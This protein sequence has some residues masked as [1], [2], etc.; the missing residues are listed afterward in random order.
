MEKDTC[1]IQFDSELLELP[2]AL[3]GRLGFL[4]IIA[5]ARAIESDLCNSRRSAASESETV[6]IQRLK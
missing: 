6:A 1:D 5:I 3:T 4:Q 2:A